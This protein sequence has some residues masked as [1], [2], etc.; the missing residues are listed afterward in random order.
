MAKKN[1]SKGKKSQ[2]ISS[3]NYMKEKARTLPIG[4]CYITPGWEREG[5]ASIIVSRIRPSGNLVVGYYLVDTFC[6]GVK[7]ADHWENM[8]PYDFEDLLR[9]AKNE[10]H[11][12]ETDYNF[13]HNLIY[14]AIEFAEEAGI[15][16]PREFNKAQYILEEDDE[17]IPLMEFEFGKNGKHF[18][19]VTPDG[20]EKLYLK[21]LQERLGENFDFIYLEDDWEEFDDSYL[22]D[23][24][25]SP[26]NFDFDF[27]DED[28]IPA[29]DSEPDFEEVKENVERMTNLIH[30][31]QEGNL[32]NFISSLS[33]EEKDRH[34]ALLKKVM[35]G[36]NKERKEKERHPHE[37]Y[38]YKYPLYP[39]HLSL[40]F[41]V[42]KEMLLRSD[43]LN[44]GEIKFILE[45][46]REKAVEDISRIVLYSIGKTKDI[47]N[48]TEKNRKYT[49]AL[50]NSM[51]LLTEMKDPTGLPVI[52]ETLRQSWDF[53]DFHFG[54]ITVDAIGGALIAC[55]KSRLDIIENY[56][57]ERGLE[58]SLKFV[59]IESLE[60]LGRSEEEY[61]EKVFDLF[62]RLMESMFTRIAKADGCDAEISGFL[63]GCMVGFHDKRSLPIIKKYFDNDLV[64]LT[65]ES[66]YKTVEKDILD[67]SFPDYQHKIP[68]S[69]QEL[70]D[71][72]RS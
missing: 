15:M 26:D 7:N 37:K 34:F 11:V 45:L 56:L 51:G 23:N 38:S 65:Y 39:T 9:K 40:H 62:M 10:L 57:H 46:P 60:I 12:E 64:D 6:L 3:K 27:D 43:F 53:E 48:Q 22:D 30:N 24:F 44:E 36:M 35:N 13:V 19:I 33:P 8:T 29:E 20:R 28:E 21:R 25:D 61:R 58:R 69:I 47:K 14:G 55:G 71:I 67:T 68:T 66:D 2:N 59:V 41:P 52:L 1:K 54:D 5:L 70:Y 32:D 42:L 16:P 50:L 72:M 31:Y 17:N 18:L 63:I 4:K 49:W